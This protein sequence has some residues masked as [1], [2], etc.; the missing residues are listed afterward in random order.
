[1]SALDTQ[2]SLILRHLQRGAPIFRGNAQR[3]YDCKH[4][5][6]RIAELRDAGHRIK[7]VMGRGG[8]WYWM[9]GAP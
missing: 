2:K 1:M 6:S 5:R 8:A 3:L 9:E 7:T 4:L